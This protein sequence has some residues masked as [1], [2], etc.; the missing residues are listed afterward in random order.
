MPCGVGAVESLPVPETVTLVPDPG[1]PAVI[2][3][4]ALVATCVG[5][6]I[7]VPSDLV[8]LNTADS[9]LSTSYSAKPTLATLPPGWPEKSIVIV[10]EPVAPTVNCKAFWAGVTPPL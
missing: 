5:A 1:V 9:A 4:K 8:A 10:L 3:L 2:E 7:V 6:M